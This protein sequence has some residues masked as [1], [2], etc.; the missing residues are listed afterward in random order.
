M[1]ARTYS[2]DHWF[3]RKRLLLERGMDYHCSSL[4]MGQQIRNAATARKLKVRLTETKE[5]IEVVILRQQ[6]QPLCPS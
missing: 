2:W 1:A 5:G 4:A 6:E 3:K